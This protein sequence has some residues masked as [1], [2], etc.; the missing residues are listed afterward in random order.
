MRARLAAVL[1]LMLALA[2]AAAAAGGGRAAQIYFYA[3]TYDPIGTPYA[4]NLLTVHPRLV[5]MAPDGHWVIANVTW[6]GWG[7]SSAHGVGISDASDCNPNCAAGTRKRTPATI[8]LSNPMRLLGHTVYGCFQLTIPAVPAAN[9]HLCIKRATSGP[10]YRYESSGT[11]TTPAKPAAG[12]DARFY[13]PSR[14]ISCEIFD[15]GGAQADV[16]CLM[17]NP[18]ASV[19]LGPD[20]HAD[21]CQHRA[22]GH[23]TG[24][25]GEGP[26]FRQLPY[27][28]SVSVGRF[29]CSS[30]TTGI[31]CIVRA[32]GKGFFMSVQLVRPVG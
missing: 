25:F 9:Q 1:A 31:T 11:G 14:N 4:T 13:T 10:G 20:G 24:N 5:P 12:S 15:D 29:R 21:I 8:V 26:S 3:D 6:T 16:G 30:A 28:R 17:I 22:N 7:T 23:C 32:T 2:S 19:N 18:Q 27:G